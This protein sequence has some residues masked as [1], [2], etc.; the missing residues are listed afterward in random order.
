VEGNGWGVIRGICLEG[1]RKTTVYPSQRG[2]DP[3]RDTKPGR[4]EYKAGVSAVRFIN[5]YTSCET[6]IVSLLHLQWKHDCDALEL[7]CSLLILQLR[8]IINLLMAGGY[9]RLFIASFNTE[10]SS[11]F[12]YNVTRRVHATIVAVEKQ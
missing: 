6:V 2:G 5:W 10:Q 9:C 1:L 8:C 12:M 3:D 7:V 4:P 11:Q